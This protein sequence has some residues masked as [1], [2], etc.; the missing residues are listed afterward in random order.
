MSEKPLSGDR[1]FARL[2]LAPLAI[3]VTSAMFA[4]AFVC[5]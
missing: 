3:A 1:E 2:A 4:V 5:W